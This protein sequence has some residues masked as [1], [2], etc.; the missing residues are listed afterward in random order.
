MERW[1]GRSRCYKRVGDSVV[2]QKVSRGNG[3]VGNFIGRGRGVRIFLKRDAA[4]RLA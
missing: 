2:R 3:L 4:F 1:Q